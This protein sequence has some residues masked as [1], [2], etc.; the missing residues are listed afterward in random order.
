M[1]RWCASRWQNG[2]ISH[3]PTHEVS[4]YDSLFGWARVERIRV[5]T[6]ACVCALTKTLVVDNIR[7]HD[8]PGRIAHGR[9]ATES[10]NTAVRQLL[11]TH[12]C[13]RCW[14]LLDFTTVC[15]VNDVQWITGC[16]N[17][18]REFTW[19]A[20]VDDCAHTLIKMKVH[21]HA[22]EQVV[23]IQQRGNRTKTR[24]SLCV[25]NQVNGFLF[26]CLSFPG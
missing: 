4:L 22:V 19:C 23:L 11:N 18:H 1:H 12:A 25:T 7:S 24:R 2:R 15:A 5:M 26:N 16:V 10:E 9:I 20:L 3:D 13:A 17:L 14:S 6:C 21:A 8:F